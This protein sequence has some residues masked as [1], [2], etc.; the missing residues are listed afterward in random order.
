MNAICHRCGSTKTSAFH[1]CS[2]CSHT[3]RDTDRVVAWLFSNSH[4]D[5]DELKLASGRIRAGELPEPSPALCAH[6][7]ARMGRAE[8]AEYPDT[9]LEGLEVFAVA[10]ANLLL[11]PLAGL[12]L[13]W[14]LKPSRP[15]A[16]RQIMRVTVPIATL[17]GLVWSAL[18][19]DRLFG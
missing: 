11:T 6:A 8:S 7:R 4:L 14:G 16:A 1:S 10:L 13:W 17:L 19:F 9:P 18:V 2:D 3:P 12:A 5:E 15:S